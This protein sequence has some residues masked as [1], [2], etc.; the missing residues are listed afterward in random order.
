MWRYAAEPI[1]M[2]FSISTLVPNV[3]IP[4]K[5]YVDSLTSLW[6]AAP[7]K[8]T[9]SILIGTTL[10]TVLHYRA[11]CDISIVKYYTSVHIPYR[12]MCVLCSVHKVTITSFAVTRLYGQCC[13]RFHIVGQPLVSDVS[14]PVIRSWS[15][16]GLCFES[17][18]NNLL[19]RLLISVLGTSILL[20]LPNIACPTTWQR[21]RGD[22]VDTEFSDVTAPYLYVEL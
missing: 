18:N 20:Q 9:F 3:I 5:F 8:V 6:E 11:D 19:L 2:P 16:C 7:P 17:N 1:D 22:C 13:C 21:V 14:V 15:I 12:L 10:T 4:E